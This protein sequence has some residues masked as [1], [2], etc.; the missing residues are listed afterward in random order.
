MHV[1]LYYVGKLYTRC[2]LTTIF[3]ACEQSVTSMQ[4]EN[5]WNDIHPLPIQADSSKDILFLICGTRSKEQR[6]LFERDIKRI[7]KSCNFRERRISRVPVGTREDKVAASR[8][9][10]WC[11]ISIMLDGAK[12]GV[13][14]M[15]ELC[16]A[17]LLDT[18]TFLF[19]STSYFFSHYWRNEITPPLSVARNSLSLKNG[20]FEARTPTPVY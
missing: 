4:K 1:Y 2:L 6:N 17:N 14:K 15:Q 5:I 11:K 9:H 12:W 20:E 13:Y 19:F 16:L 10:K 18:K 7:L 8:K 3:F